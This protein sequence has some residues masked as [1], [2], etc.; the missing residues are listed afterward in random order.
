MSSEQGGTFLSSGRW[1][2]CGLKRVTHRELSSTNC[3]R[4]D[5]AHSVAWEPVHILR[6][7]TRRPPR[8]VGQAT[9]HGDR[10]KEV[11]V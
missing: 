1:G 8:G 5:S 4:Q 6:G 10:G 2:H 9:H 7:W 3:S 11:L